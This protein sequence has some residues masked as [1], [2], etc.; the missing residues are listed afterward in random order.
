MLQEKLL[1]CLGCPAIAGC[2][3]KRHNITDCMQL[4]IGAHEV[5]ELASSTA[6]RHGV[7]PHARLPLR[8]FCEGVR[9]IIY[10][11]LL[12][13]AAMRKIYSLAPALP[14]GLASLEP[15]ILYA[16]RPSRRQESVSMG[17]GGGGARAST[18]NKT[19]VDP[20]SRRLFA[21]TGCWRYGLAP[22][23]SDARQHELAVDPAAQQPHGEA[24]LRPFSPLPTPSG[25]SPQTGTP[26]G[27]SS[28]QQ[29]RQEQEQAQAGYAGNWCLAL[30]ATSP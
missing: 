13:R 8:K 12:N 16:S 26:G 10:D 29:R 15:Y 25:G 14:S 22:R 5:Q 24:G 27:V 18:F 11:H 2:P 21:F 28:G 17:W 3:Q 6:C 30:R 20:A 7:L 9:F 4:L 19:L 23:A 1:G